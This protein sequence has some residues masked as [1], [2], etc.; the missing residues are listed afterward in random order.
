MK[1]FF[2]LLLVVLML[3]PSIIAC[4]DEREEE[5]PSNTTTTTKAP[6]STTPSS[7]PSTE[8]PGTEGTGSTGTTGSTGGNTDIPV[9]PPDDP[10]D[11]PEPPPTTTKKWNGQTLNILATNW[12]QDTAG[13]PWSQVELAVGPNDY[14]EEV[15]FGSIINGAVLDRAEFIK[16]E[17]GVNLK[18]IA[19]RSTQIATVLSDA[20]VGGSEDTRYHI[21]MP[22]MLEVQS[23][24]GTNSVYNIAESDYINLDKSY[25]NQV[26][27][28]AYTINGITLFAAGDFSFLDEQTSFLIYYNEA[29]TMGFPNFPNLYQMVREGKWTIDQ[30]TNVAKLVSKNSGVS[31]W[32]DEDTYGFGTNSLSHFFH[33][34]GIQQVSVGD[35]GFYEL[36][37][38]QERVGTL[39]DKLLVISAAEWARTNWDGG[40]VA[41]QQAFEEGRLLFYDEVVQKTDYFTNQT[42]EFKVGILPAP[43]LSESQDTYYTPCAN[44]SV[45]MCIPKATTDREMSEYFFEILSYTGQ[46]YVMAAYKLNLKNK[47]NPETA[48]ESMDIIENYIFANLCYDQGY[49]YQY[50]GLLSGVQYASYSSGKNNFAVEYG[51]AAEDAATTLEEWNLYWKCYTDR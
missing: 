50:S 5:E 45:V 9:T 19:A 48:D 34:S 40:Y 2:A 47:L 15:G 23:I 33:Y 28:E 30:M 26:A 36:S 43:K 8:N 25:Y 51:Q 37:L 4:G 42:D 21:A 7:T 46:K 16:K 39:I 17:Y 13:A 35:D 12:H 1:K 22:R 41:L 14:N 27:R 18:W 10:G 31:D 24:V 44:Q 6:E 49:M 32:T 38:N 20:V 3:L 11:G 29:M